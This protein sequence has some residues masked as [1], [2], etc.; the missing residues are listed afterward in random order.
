MTE[1]YFIHD[2]YARPFRIDID[3]KSEYVHVHRIIPDDGPIMSC[4]ECPDIQYES[5]PILTFEPKKI[6]I[7]KSPLNKMTEFSGGHGSK[8]DGNSILLHMGNNIYVFIGWEIFSFTSLDTITSY[9]SPVGNNDVPYPYA[10]D[11][12][13]S[14]Y[15][16]IDDVVI[17]H[18]D[19]IAEQMLS[20]DDPYS[21]Y[22]HYSLATTTQKS[23]KIEP[24]ENI[25][26]FNIGNVKYNLRYTPTPDKD[27]D[28]WQYETKN[29][30][31]VIYQ[32]GK[33]Q[34]L[35]KNDYI[36]LINDFGK[37][38]SFEPFTQKIVHYPRII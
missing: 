34:I 6:F 17:V 1:S 8:F 7:G 5:F 14:Y 10:V 28:R 20:Y 23:I 31:S 15:L 22:Y 19:K 16:L 35:S 32:N 37:Y 38:S 27:Y 21:Y 26:S 25:K 3:Q 9:I 33:K 12:N 30:Y 18:N 36:N 4:N 13:G 2:N 24:F 29:E 11:K